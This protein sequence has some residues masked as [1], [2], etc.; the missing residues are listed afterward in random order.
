MENAFGIIGGIILVSWIIAILDWLAR[1]KERRS[2]QRPA[3]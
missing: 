2:K 3:A 1:R